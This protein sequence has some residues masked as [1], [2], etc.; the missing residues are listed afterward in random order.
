MLWLSLVVHAIVFSDS[1]IGHPN[2][3]PISARELVARKETAV[4]RHLVAR[5]CAESI[6]SHNLRRKAK[7]SLPSSQMQA[8]LEPSGFE[9]LILSSSTCVLAPEAMEGP[10][11]INNEMI[12]NNLTEGQLGVPLT[13]DIAVIDVTTCEPMENVLVEIWAANATGPPSRGDGHHGQPGHCHYPNLGGKE[14][15]HCPNQ[16]QHSEKGDHNKMP[17]GHGHGHEH[18]PGHGR[19]GGPEGLPSQPLSRNETFLRGG[20]PTS[21]D[22]VVELV[23]I[24]PGFYA[25]RTAHIHTMIHMNWERSDN[26]TFVST[27]GSVLHIGQFFFQ[28]TWNDKV[29][30]TSPYIENNNKRTH[31]N[32]DRQMEDSE[33]ADGNS[34]ILDIS[35]A[36]E[37]LTEGLVGFG[38]VV[39]D[40]RASY[41]ITN[42]NYLNSTNSSS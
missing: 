22:G 2:H 16:D 4:K 41:Q 34:A 1:V 40:P 28:E 24:Y 11:Y 31:N 9:N 8:V 18:K 39:V 25:G 27:S 36:G 14:E 7:R 13:L 12:R 3:E 23:T 6:A 33:D 35:A 21:S 26:G 15:N 17:N 32:E 5:S 10:Y 38:T 19:P 42:T 37:D 29:Y 30:A 20:A